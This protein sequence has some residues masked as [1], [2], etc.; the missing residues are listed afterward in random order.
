MFSS[1]ADLRKLADIW[2]QAPRV[3]E[4]R[5]AMSEEDRYRD[6]LNS[7]D[8]S[9]SSAVNGAVI[10]IDMDGGV[11]HI[12]IMDGQPGGM[13]HLGNYSL[14]GE[15]SQAFQAALDKMI[16]YLAGH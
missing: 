8:S 14:S 15:R 6:I 12:T 1:E 13:P 10:C 4:R 2:A 5:A 7:K 9:V 3:S 16:V 11:Y